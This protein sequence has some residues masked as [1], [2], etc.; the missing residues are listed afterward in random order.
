MIRFI[1]A[2]AALL[3][4]PAIACAQGTFPSLTPP[5]QV[6]AGPN[7]GGVS[8]LPAPRALVLPDLPFTLSGNT[9]VVA[10]VTG[11]LTNGHCVSIGSGGN[12]VDAG[13]ACSGAGGGGTVNSA[14]IGQYAIYTAATAVSGVT[15][16]GGISC[17]ASGVCTLANPS[18]STLGGIESLVAT[19]HKWINTISTG[20]VPAVTQ[21]DASDVTFTQSG[22]GAVQTDLST[23]GKNVVYVSDFGAV[24]NGSTDDT[25]SIQNAINSLPAAG[26]TV[27]FGALNYKISST[28]LIG[29]GTL[30][31]ISTKAGV[32]LQGTN[33]PG[34]GASIFPFTTAT[35]TKLTW[36]GGANPMIL[37]QGPLSG[38]GVQNMYIDGNG[39]TAS[40]CIN[41]ASAQNGDSRNLT[42]VNCKQGIGST[43]HPVSGYSGVNDV[44]SWQN[45][46]TNISVV[47][48]A[49]ANF[50]IVLTGASDGSSDTDYN[51]F[52]G[53]TILVGGSGVGINMQVSDGNVFNSTRIINLSGT[54]GGVEYD[55][56]VKNNFPNGNIF[57]GLDTSGLTIFNNSSPVGSAPNYIIGLETQNGTTTPVL[58]NL[59]VYGH[60]IVLNGVAG[61]SCA[62]GTV[63][64]ATFVATAGIVTH[65]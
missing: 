12:I 9:S 36:A 58:A 25:T 2:C 4:L 53:T 43:S 50:G 64:A 29:N 37:I 17:N 1:A 6:L 11:A 22:T 41:P 51:V 56:S 65:C 45:V 3:A 52:N 34:T 7:G 28:L 49:G 62:A 5:N 24:G 48:P 35:G 59:T 39:G 44:D 20:G 57:N 42:L 46:W 40:V 19:S 47:V 31:A 55:Y 21:P 14:T 61:V 60:A 63:N 38:W 8:A 15:L 32:V 30:S 23:R 26:G 16:S 13:S 27:V 54:P 18:A 33:N 10:T